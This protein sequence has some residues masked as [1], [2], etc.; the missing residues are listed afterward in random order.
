MDYIYFYFFVLFLL[1]KI[2]S[3]VY[4]LG[5]SSVVSDPHV[6]VNGYKQD[7]NQHTKGVYIQKDISIYIYS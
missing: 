2:C 3:R 7:S 4:A 5:H 6:C 1:L